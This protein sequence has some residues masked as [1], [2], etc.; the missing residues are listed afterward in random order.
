M[1]EALKGQEKERKAKEEERKAQ[2]KERKAKEEERKA[3]EE[4]RKAKEEALKDAANL[5]RRIR[6]MEAG[7]TSLLAAVSGKWQGETPWG[8]L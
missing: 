5:R 8:S 3:K 7:S 1:S 4:K 6:E 2:E